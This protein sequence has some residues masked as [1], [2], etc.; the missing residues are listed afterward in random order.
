MSTHKNDLCQRPEIW[1]TEAYGRHIF[2]TMAP[3]T[4]PCPSL[5]T[6]AGT[7]ANWKKKADPTAAANP[8][9]RQEF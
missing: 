4:R 3:M 7:V 8:L 6:S 5:G 1:L 2:G 9:K